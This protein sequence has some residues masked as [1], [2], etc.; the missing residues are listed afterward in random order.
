MNVKPKRRYDASSRRTQAAASRQA[1][2]EASKALFAKRGFDGV[3]IDEIAERAGVASPTV[4]AAFKS[5]AGILKEIIATT[6]F[7]DTYEVL[8][9]Q[10]QEARDPIELL[11]I[12]AAISRTIFDREK[13]EIGIIRGASAFSRELQSVEKKFEQM[14]FDLQ[15]SR[16]KLLVAR[17]AHARALGLSRVRDIMWMFTGR[18]V[19]RMLVLERGWSSDA[20]ETFVAASLI[21]SLTGEVPRPDSLAAYPR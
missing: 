19:Y 3:T 4:Y 5:K 14:R 9:R 18:D 20:Y 1:I 8:A 7:G 11:R 13:A 17:Y 12:T 2:L 15:E 10:L 16:A 6:F 21:G